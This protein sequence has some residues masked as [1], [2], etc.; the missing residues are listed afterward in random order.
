MSRSQRRTQ[1]QAA[2][3][4]FRAWLDRCVLPH[5]FVE[6]SP[7]TFPDGLRGEIKRPD[8]LVGL[9]TIGT[10]AVDVKAKR[11]YAQTL[12]IDADEHR[13][14]ANFET[15]FNISVWFACFPPGSGHDCHL[16]LNR[17]L[18]GLPVTTREGK[19][20]I[21]VPL[22]MTKVVDERRDFV[23]ALMGAFRLRKP[24]INSKSIL[25]P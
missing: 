7:L 14:L 3:D 1:G 25:Q 9:P 13:T 22:K 23:A 6:Q 15:F 5:L 12:I 10:I 11:V 17:S 16:F 2:E 21:A 18:V 24:L 20:S 4:R 8:F 19:A